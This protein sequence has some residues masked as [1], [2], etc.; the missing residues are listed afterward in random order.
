MKAA[1]RLAAF[2]FLAAFATSAASQETLRIGSVSPLTGPGAAWGLAIEGGARIAADE[3]NAKGGLVVG[4]KTYKVEVVSY[5]DEYKTASTVTAVNRLIE[6][7]GVNFIIGPLGAASLL[8]VKGIADRNQ[9]IMMTNTYTVKALENTQFVF[10]VLPTSR[11]FVPPFV[12]WLAEN[13]PA[14]KKVAL[15]APNDETGWDSQKVQ[16]EAYRKNGFTIVGAELFERSQTDFRAMLTKLLAASPDSIE[17]D[18]TPPPTAGLVIRQARELGF[19]GQFTKFGG[20]NVNDMVKAA[21]AEN[22]EGTLGYFA[23]DPDSKEWKWLEEQYGKYHQ[24]KMG[25]FTFFFYDATKLLLA[26]IAKAGSVTDTVKVRA[27]IEKASPFETLLGKS[28]WAGKATYGVDRQLF[29][30]VFLGEITGGKGRVITKL[31][32]QPQ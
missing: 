15:V 17:L 22:V 28:A 16:T 31:E 5:D 21:G 27:E 19:K 25:D 30:P 12:K 9:V 8:A 4:G 26:S 1:K 10:R 14:I 2:A 32:A 20:V 7:D 18:T 23:G 11:E 3:V 6:R 29:T 24:N 13:R